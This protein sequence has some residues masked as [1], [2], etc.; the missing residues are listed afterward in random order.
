MCRRASSCRRLFAE[1]TWTRC[2]DARCLKYSWKHSRHQ[3]CRLLPLRLYESSGKSRRH[4]GQCLEARGVGARSAGAAAAT[5][6]A[7]T[8]TPRVQTLTEDRATPRVEAM[9]RTL[10]PCAQLLRRPASDRF[11]RIRLMI[12]RA[13]DIYPLSNPPWSNGH[14]AG[15]W[16]CALTITPQ[17]QA[18]LIL[19][20]APPWC[21]GQH[22]RFSFSKPEF[23]SPWGYPSGMPANIRL[24][25][26]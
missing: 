21:S 5:G 13:A 22:A 20:S 16:A 17:G 25:R 3:C 8:L 24:C 10:T 4:R 14:D 6:C 7:T 15:L 1:A 9:R 23:N 26:G 18:S 19:G 11:A 2:V 12:P